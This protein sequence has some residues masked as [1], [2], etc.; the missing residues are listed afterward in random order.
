[1]VTDGPPER[2]VS[3]VRL[4]IFRTCHGPVLKT[5]AVPSPS[6]QVAL[7]HDLKSLIAVFNRS[8]ADSM[9]VPAE[10]LEVVVTRR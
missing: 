7:E 3:R 2:R 1:M 6:V 9:V 10:Y 8:G 4:D 5:L